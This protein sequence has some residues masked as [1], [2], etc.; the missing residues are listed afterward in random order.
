MNP[1]HE[2]TRREIGI[3]VLLVS[4]V[5]VGL[6]GAAGFLVY[7]NLEHSH[8]L[9]MPLLLTVGV[10]LMLAA[11]AAYAVVLHG[12]GLS[13]DSQGRAL[14]LP[15]GSVRAVLA[16][17]LVLVFAI[18]SV[19]L[20]WQ[21]QMP[22]GTVSPGLTAEQI[23]LL[24]AGTI[25]QITPVA[26]SSPQVFDVVIQQP[27]AESATQ[28]AQQ[29]VTVLATLVTAVAAF[30]FGASTVKDAKTATEAAADKVRAAE[31][32]AENAR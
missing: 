5:V 24:P 10:V 17:A 25:R 23:A 7:A 16:L 8:E 26:S 15:E 20:F 6:V 31:A 9:V 27:T 13:G 21:L 22:P 18:L 28:V 4:L 12:A 30:Y 3:V 2:I 32:A 11:L 14:G 1:N 29:L 19:F